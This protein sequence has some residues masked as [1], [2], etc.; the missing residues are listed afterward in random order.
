MFRRV[1]V[2]A[3]ALLALLAATSRASSTTISP[4]R[5]VSLPTWSPDGTQIAF[6][7]R[8]WPPPTGHRNP[9]SILQALCTMNADGTNAQPLRYTVCSSN[10]PDPPGPIVWFQSGLLYL[11]DGAIFRLVP[12]SKPQTVARIY[13]VSIVTNPTGTRIA[14][15]KY[16]DS[17]LS[18][19]GPVTIL[20]AQSGAVVG[21]AGGKKLD[22]VDPSLSPDGTRVAFEREASNDSGKTFGIWT[23]KT[24]GSNLR[25][26]VKVG[27]LPLWSPT[28]GKIAYVA[29][30]RSRVAL[31]LI[32][33]GGGKSR[34]LV[35][36]I[37]TVF[38]WSP[39]GKSIAF[40]TSKGKLA[41][42]AVATGKVRTLIRLNSP[43]VA[44]SPDSSELV[45]NSVPS[46]QACGASFAAKPWLRWS[47]W[48]VPVD[49]SKPT[50][51]SSCT[52]S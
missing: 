40:E 6:Y 52:G 21:T 8:R 10:C 3:V 17:C 12:G 4:C 31:R 25:R 28:G 37:T 33:A 19:A 29:G 7:G 26:L 30:A 49:G 50:L 35:R 45:A 15:E 38:A 27:G 51:I 14:A 2:V 18:C 9:N 13:A 41:V 34:A 11:R 23:A 43:T 48:R 1:L 22:N 20:D 32:S 46:R 36:N 47:T 5:Q 39:D 16:Y 42:V 24:N 44:W